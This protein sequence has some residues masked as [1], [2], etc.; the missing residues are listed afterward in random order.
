MTPKSSPDEI[1]ETPTSPDPADEESSTAPVAEPDVARSGAAKTGLAHKLYTGALSYDFIGRRRLW[2]LVSAILVVV[3][4]ASFGIRGLNLGIE[5]TG[6]AEFSV[7]AEPSDD[8]ISDVRT[9]VQDLDLPD[10]GSITVQQ[11][12]Q[13]AVRVQTRSLDVDEIPQ[14]QRAI[15]DVAGVDSTDVAY[16][17]I[18]ASWGDQITNRGLIALVVFLA[19]VSVLIWVYFREAKMAVSAL[20]ALAHDL[21]ITVGVFAL[22]GFSFTPAS[23]IGMLTILGYSLYDTVVVFDKV[24]ENTTGLRHSRLTYSQAANNAINQVLVRSINTTII[25]VLPVA[26]LLVTGVFVLGTGP[27]KDV[28]LVLFVGMIAGAYSSIFIATPV[29]AQLKEREPEMVAQRKR[30][31]RRLEKD[32]AK[33]S[34]TV[35]T[36]TAEDPEPT[37]HPPKKS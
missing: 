9:A 10:M 3:S 14:V 1:D 11:V 32:A 8:T 16:S 12:G 18:G 23:L 2:Y 13:N 28:G 29:L 5:F 33:V 20:V 4:V 25:G 19:L 15:A 27:L 24:R 7:S 30:V 22:V 17:L 21:V 35:T 26:A 31:K 34:V 6:G 37:D 36:T